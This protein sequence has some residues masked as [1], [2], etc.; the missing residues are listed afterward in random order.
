MWTQNENRRGTA[1]QQKTALYKKT[2]PTDG[3]GPKHAKILQSSRK[4][5]GQH[6][7]RSVHAAR[8]QAHKKWNIWNM[9]YGTYVHT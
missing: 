9:E 3:L 6:F 5:Q 2:C 8:G 7:A 4:P 1:M